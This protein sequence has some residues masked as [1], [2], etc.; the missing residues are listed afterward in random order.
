[1]AFRINTKIS[2][3]QNEWL[4]KKAEEMGISKSALVAVAI[5]NYIKEIEVVNGLPKILDQLEKHGVTLEK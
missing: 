4:D 1:M 2:N 5:E 3:R